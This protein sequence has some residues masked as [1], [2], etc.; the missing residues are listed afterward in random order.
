MTHE[1]CEILPGLFAY[2]LALPVH[3]RAK[4]HCCGGSL[5]GRVLQNGSSAL[6]EALG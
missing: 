6:P 5:L 3:E 2:I 1:W 4:S